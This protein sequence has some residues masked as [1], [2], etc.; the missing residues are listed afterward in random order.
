VKNDTNQ[1][2]FGYPDMGR[3]GLGHSLLAWARCVVWCEATGATMLPPLWLR[4]RLGPYLRGE[5]DKREYF[6]LFRMPALKVLLKRAALLMFA[7]KTR[8]VDGHLGEDVFNARFLEV[9]S[10]RWPGHVVIFNNAGADNEVKFFHFVQGHSKLLRERFWEMVK[11][12]YHPQQLALAIALHVRMG[13]FAT[14][15]NPTDLTDNNMRLPIAWYV[16]VLRQLRLQLGSRVPAVVYSDGADIEISTLLAEPDV[17]RAKRQESVTDLIGIASAPVLVAS[18]SGF[19]LWGAFFGQVPTI[20]YPGKKKVEI[21]ENPSLTI[22]NDGEE[23]LPDNFMRAVSS[24][25][26][27]VAAG[28]GAE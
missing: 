13:D 6:K 12:R 16:A 2:L 27:T 14:A 1:K 22:E 17:R 23:N 20:H 26:K 7:G 8:S 21:L 28:T 15:I 19:S 9:H 25:M 11:P 4:P 24:R 18:G 3:T 10:N 5:R